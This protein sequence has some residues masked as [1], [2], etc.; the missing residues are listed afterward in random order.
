MLNVASASSNERI[1]ATDCTF[2]EKSGKKTEGLDFFYNG[3]HSKSERGL[4]WSLLSIIDLKQGTGYSLSAQ[5]TPAGLSQTGDKKSLTTSDTSRVDAYL[6]HLK[7]N[8]GHFPKDIRYLANDAFYS[9]K[10]W[11][12][13][14]VDLNLHDIGKL[15]CDSDLKFFY[16]GPQKPRGRRRIYGGKV[17]FTN[18]TLDDPNIESFEFVAT[19]DDDID[20]YS[21]RVYSVAFKRAIQVVYLHKVTPTSSSYVLLFS[22]DLE[23]N[24]VD[25]VRYYKARFHI[26]FIFR[27]AKQFL[28]LTHCQARDSQKLNF[29]VNSTVLALNVAKVDWQEQQRQSNQVIPF[30]MANYKRRAFNENLLSRFISMFGLPQTLNKSQEAYQELINYG[31]IDY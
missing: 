18:I 14:V 17:D 21:A 12:D 2:F 26:E 11:I 29:H 10:K 13:G 4:E 5:Q 20:L 25:I 30:S 28:G 23:L 3:S 8:R 16:R 9:K 27:D 19:L 24:P 7:Q 15:R 31:N 1:A 22:T 6:E